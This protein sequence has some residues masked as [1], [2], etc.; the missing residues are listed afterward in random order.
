MQEESI[1][2]VKCYAIILLST[3]LKAIY[4]CKVKR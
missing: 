4:Y 1:A 3:R 2:E